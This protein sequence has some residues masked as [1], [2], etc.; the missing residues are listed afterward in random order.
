MN[1][2]ISRATLIRGADGRLYAVTA[3][4]VTEVAETGARAVRSAVRS[5]DRAGFDTA[6]HEAGRFAVTP[7]A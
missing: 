7:G 4:G 1:S 3:A 2:T 5:G 6:D